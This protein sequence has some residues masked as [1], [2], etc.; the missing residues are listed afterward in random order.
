MS[1]PAVRGSASSA[2][3]TTFSAAMPLRAC[4]ATTRG[5]AGRDDVM[6]SP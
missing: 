4:T 6:S 1:S 2:A 3:V 5:R